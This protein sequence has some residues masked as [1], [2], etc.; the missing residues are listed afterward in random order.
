MGR[1]LLERSNIFPYHVYA[2]SNNKDW[3]SAPL[4]NIYDIFISE[5]ETIAMRYRFQIHAFVLMSNHFHLVLSTPFANLDS[6]MQHLMTQSS[7]GIARSCN[8]INK[9]Y[10]AR[11]RWTIIREPMHY[12]YAMKYVYRNPVQSNIVEKAEDY[13]WSTLNKKHHKFPGLAPN[14]N[15][16][17]EFIPQDR[18]G[19]LYWI[20]N[21]FDKEQEEAIRK[22]LNKAEFKFSRNSGGY[23]FQF[24]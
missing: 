16:F 21:D 4:S 19:L 9:I 15:G 10:G 20:N 7:K 22:A 12:A 2:R 18:Q 17:N 3:F 14:T 6:G 11:Y 1:K 5:F 13:L 24:R 23:L 8:R